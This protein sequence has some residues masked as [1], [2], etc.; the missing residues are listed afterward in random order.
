M[1]QISPTIQGAVMLLMLL[2]S[3]LTFAV[4]PSPV[5]VDAL[6]AETVARNPELQFYE[7]EIAAARGGSTSAGAWANP[8]LGSE[9]GHKSVH[10][11]GGNNIGDG[12]S[13]SVSLSQTFEFPGRLS[14]RKAIANRQVELA[15][16]G[17]Q[18][19]RA[20]LAM[21]ARSLAYRLLAAQQRAAAAD[22]VSKRFQDLLAVLV[23]RDV[24]GIAPMLETR[25]VEASALTLN[26]R[27]SEARIAARDA[28]FELN[29]LRGL[30]ISTPVEVSRTHLPLKPAPA[31]D[32]LLATARER[33]FSIRAR[34]AELEQQ[35]L[36]VQLS[37]NERWPSVRVAPFIK[38]ENAGDR[39]RQVGLGV[40][41]PLPLLNLNAGN[42]E[43][44]KARETQAEVALTVAL[45]EVER[46]I[47]AARNAY[48]TFLAEIARSPTD[49]VQK[50]RD[51]ARMGDEHYRLGAL[52]IGTYTALQTQYLD[53]VDALL[54]TQADALEARQQLELF[55]GLKLDDEPVAARNTAADQSPL[56]NPLPSLPAND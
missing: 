50:F 29:Q 55:S 51:A 2:R 42:I 12:P 40:S 52:P 28:Q 36:R 54:S 25:I 45:R 14:L 17:L 46:R 35:G 31:L 5:A 32:T 47:A 49:A 7:A 44:A 22:E 34:I 11:L 21:R 53:A 16:L 27:S 8:E 37:R 10:D 4:E 26:R 15:E 39:E 56:S 38:E 1:G 48:E 20:A 18:Q 23:Q 19:F 24:A 30:P 3:A 33:N 13:W 41:I 43:A 6:V 9:L